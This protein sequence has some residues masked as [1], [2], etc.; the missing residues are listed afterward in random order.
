MLA[1]IYTPHLVQHMLHVLHRSAQ[2]IEFKQFE[3]ILP[4]ENCVREGTYSVY[5]GRTFSLYIFHI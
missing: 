5:R 4:R 3:K 2:T 1:C